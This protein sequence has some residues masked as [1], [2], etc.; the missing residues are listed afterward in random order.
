VKGIVLIV[1]GLLT[2]ACTRAQ[3]RSPQATAELKNANGKVVGNAGFREDANGVR[4]VVQVKAVTPG[5]HG[6]HIHAAGKCDPPGFTSAGGH[7]NPAGKK[8]GLKSPEGPHAGD[9]PNIEV[10]A[11]GNGRLEHVT[12][13]ITLGSGATSLFDADGSA[14][15]LHANPDDEQTDPT[16]DAGGRIGCGLINK[17]AQ[18]SGSAP[19]E[20]PTSGGY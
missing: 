2:P 4:I 20:S 1:V 19:H 10:G 14:L 9:L 13:L 18:A 11:D 3:S 5:R 15:V 12:K 7:F 17:A 16:G 6:V 8:H